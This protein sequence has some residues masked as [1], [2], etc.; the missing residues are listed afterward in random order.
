MGDENNALPFSESQDRI[1][2]GKISIIF[3]NNRKMSIFV[4]PN[5]QTMKSSEL[6]LIE[7][8]GW[9]SGKSEAT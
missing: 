2:N 8:D 1:F 5:N 7:A 6:Q 3:V 4:V 9:L